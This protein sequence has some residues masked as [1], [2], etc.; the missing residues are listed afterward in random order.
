MIVVSLKYIRKCISIFQNFDRIALS[1]F[2]SWKRD[3]SLLMFIFICTVLT[4]PNC[5]VGESYMVKSNKSQQNI[6][7][8]LY[9]RDINIDGDLL[10]S[11]VILMTEYLGTV[12]EFKIHMWFFTYFCVCTVWSFSVYQRTFKIYYWT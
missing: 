1:K 8:H 2:V 10:K 6:K 11:Y 4:H 7:S 3:D 9:C 5:T 12:Y